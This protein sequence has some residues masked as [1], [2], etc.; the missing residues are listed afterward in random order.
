LEKLEI[1]KNLTTMHYVLIWY[2]M[3]FVGGVILIVSGLIHNRVV[4]LKDILI[5]LVAALLGG[6]LL[7]LSFLSVFLEVVFPEDYV[8]IKGKNS[9]PGSHDM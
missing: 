2:G 1:L 4:T 7:L 6:V 9:D 3:G 8:V 5:C